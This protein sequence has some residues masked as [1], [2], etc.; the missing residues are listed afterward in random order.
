MGA[1]VP[2]EEDVNSELIHDWYGPPAGT[3]YRTLVQNS[4]CLLVRKA[5]SYK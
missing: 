3:N 5:C 1:S 2:A 4:F